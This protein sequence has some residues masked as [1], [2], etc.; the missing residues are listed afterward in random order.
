MTLPATRSGLGALF[1][2]RSVALIGASAEATSISARPLRLLRQHGFRGA[3]YPVN[4]KYD[5]LQGLTVYPSIGAVPEAVDLAPVVG[6]AGGVPSVLGGWGA[7]GGG[8]AL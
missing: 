6:P 2:P 3:I 4:P 5:Q 7:R 1:E 8:G